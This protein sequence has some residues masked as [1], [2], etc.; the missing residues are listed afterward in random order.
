MQGSAPSQ[1]KHT[2]RHD[3]PA[4]AELKREVLKEL[5]FLLNSPDFHSSQRAQRLLRYLVEYSLAG[6]AERIKERTIGVELFGREASYDTGQDAIVRV[7]ANDVRKRLTGHYK[8]RDPSEQRLPVRISLPP[9]CYIPEFQVI[10]SNLVN[11]KTEPARVVSLDATAEP[12]PSSKASADDSSVHLTQFQ[13]HKLVFAL[14]AFS[15]AA[16]SL[17]GYYGYSR[18]GAQDALGE[19]WSPVLQSQK[20][21]VICVAQPMVYRFPD[22]PSEDHFGSGEEEAFLPQAEQAHDVQRS[23]SGQLIPMPDTFVGVG[24]AFALAD[25]SAFLGSRGKSWQLRPGVGASS[26]DLRAAPVIL[27]G[28]YTNPWT[29]RLTQNLRFVFESGT[30][31]RDRVQQEKRWSLPKL[32]PDWKTPEDFAIISRFS[33]GETG[34]PVMV[35]AGLTNFGTQVAGE[36]LTNAN[37]LK[38]AIRQVPAGWQ[39]RNLQFVI[40]TRIIGKTPGPPTVVASHIW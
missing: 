20:P 12:T 5:E 13:K 28:A 2:P 11:A 16:G 14:I 35:A 6:N 39:K 22:Q 15:L 17:A 4:S 24:D 23:G 7:A 36:F 38:A 18:L 19:F 1:S 40:H 30:F 31:I 26:A 27:I 21:V 33:S 8:K 34:E 32:T 10:E 29:R 3:V 25:I 37:L 9:G